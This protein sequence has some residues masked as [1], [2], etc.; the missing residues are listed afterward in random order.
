M[1]EGHD[2]SK[3]PLGPDDAGADE[4]EAAEETPA[5]D[6]HAAE[7]DMDDLAAAME[8][9]ADDG[10]AR[11]VDEAGQV[12]EKASVSIDGDEL[13]EMA[14][15]AM[16]ASAATEDTFFQE[17]EEGPQEEIDFAAEGGSLMD[18]SAAP[19]GTLFRP[20]VLILVAVN[21]VVLAGIAWFVAG[22]LIE[23]ENGVPT[24]APRVA[25]PKPVGKPDVEYATERGTM[26]R[27][28]EE[29]V[30]AAEPEAAVETVRIE[31]PGPLVI[32]SLR[33][34][35]AWDMKALK[36]LAEADAV[37]V[38]AA[39][40]EGFPHVGRVRMELLSLL[41]GQAPLELQPAIVVEATIQQARALKSS[42]GSAADAL[43]PLKPKYHADLL[44]E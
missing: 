42:A 28:I 21:L 32:V 30:L 8:A 10:V 22:M 40:G 26:E 4:A 23:K 27:R 2:E 34:D 9:V 33:R 13:E 14:E 25:A 20:R 7:A 6:E 19:R 39:V 18:E 43:K 36:K 29:A 15:Q 37:K 44:E 17:V 16:A 24:G 12:D 11:E 38:L 1:N 41:G 31:Q 3:E 5:E 35:A